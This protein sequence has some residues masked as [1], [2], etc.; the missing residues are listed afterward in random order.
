MTKIKQDFLRRLQEDPQRS[1]NVIVTITSDPMAQMAQ[2]EAKGL[3]V[4]RTFSLT[5]M[6]AAT[7]P[8]EAVM[9]L[10]IEPWVVRIEPD[11]AVHTLG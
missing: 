4:T 3:T 2:V 5:P 1:V 11:E 7:G 10:A 8:A 6:L 9:E